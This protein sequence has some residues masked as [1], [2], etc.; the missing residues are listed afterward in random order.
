MH[1]LSNICIAGDATYTPVQQ[2]S[3]SSVY[4]HASVGH[5]CGK[6]ISGQLYHTVLPSFHC[7]GLSFVKENSTMSKQHMSQ[8]AR[9][10][11]FFKPRKLL[12]KAEFLLQNFASWYDSLSSYMFLGYHSS[13]GQDRSGLYQRYVL[14]EARFA[15]AVA[16]TT[17]ARSTD[18]TWP[19]EL[20]CSTESSP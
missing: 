16:I 10:A 20:W 17:V 9:T 3:M 8:K 18:I 1:I 4:Y 14:E 2:F 15:D 7:T 19:L 5:T 11:M 12:N 6:Y 13:R